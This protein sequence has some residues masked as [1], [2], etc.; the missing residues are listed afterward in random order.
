ETV[1]Y[2]TISNMLQGYEQ[3][4]E[5]NNLFNI[6]SN[7]GNEVEYIVKK[8][9]IFIV[10]KR[11]GKVIHKEDLVEEIEEGLIPLSRGVMEK[12]SRNFCSDTF[13]FQMPIEFEIKG[14]D[15]VRI[16][17]VNILINKNNS[18]FID[19]TF[20]LNHYNGEGWLSRKEKDCSETLGDKSPCPSK[21]T[22]MISEP[23]DNYV[24]MHDGDNISNK[25]NCP[26]V[27]NQDQS[28]YDNDNIGDACDNDADSD[29]ILDLIDCNPLD[30][31]TSTPD[32]NNDCGGGAEID[33]C[34]I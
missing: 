7:H 26:L 29:L 16:N 1:E 33:S 32:C 14:R 11:T 24:D 15:L 17:L 34:N 30:E 6:F 9:K 3:T 4:E 19:H 18:S 8:N 13:D 5:I 12:E 21:M 25:D 31:N 28:D 2:D 10:N 27:S 20:T 23:F 22:L